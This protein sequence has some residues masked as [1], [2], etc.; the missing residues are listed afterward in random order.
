MLYTGRSNQ[1]LYQ[2]EDTHVL[3]GLKNGHFDPPISHL[4]FVDDSTFSIRVT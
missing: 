2:K 1:L 3:E 4:L